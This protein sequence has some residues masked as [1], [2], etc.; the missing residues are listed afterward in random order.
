M[1]ESEARRFGLALME[2]AETAYLTTVG[3]N[4]F[5]QVRAMLNLRNR[6]LWP[7]LAV[8]FDGHQRDLL[9]YFSTNTSSAKVAQIK[10]NPKVSVYFCDPAHFQGLMLAGTIEI[11]TDSQLKRQIWQDGWEV[12]Y[13]GGVND[14]DYTLLRLLPTLA[15]GWNG[16]RPFG[17]TL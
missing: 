9:M 6:M 10:A 4:G 3:P 16:E 12:Y 14:P 11:I 5:P 2:K 8:V 17:F 1:D 13:P 15:K 7:A